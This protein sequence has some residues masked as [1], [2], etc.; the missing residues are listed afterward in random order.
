M[1]RDLFI[2]VGWRVDAYSVLGTYTVVG[3]NF[4]RTNAAIYIEKKNQF[5]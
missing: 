2:V 1:P 3:A 4:K 5:A